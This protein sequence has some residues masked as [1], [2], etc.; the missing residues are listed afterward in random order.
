M[1]LLSLVFAGLLALLTGSALAAGTGTS[2]PAANVNWSG[3]YIGGVAGY[4]WD[5]N[6]YRYFSQSVEFDSNGFVGGAYTFT[7]TASGGQSPYTWSISSG[8]LPPGVNLQPSSGQLSGTPTL[9]GTYVF[10]IQLSDNT[11]AFMSRPCA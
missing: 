1:R 10:S 8:A 2:V 6:T 4:G 5:S 11:G 7:I 3:A 9:A